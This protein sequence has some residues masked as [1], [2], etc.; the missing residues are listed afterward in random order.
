MN[1]NDDITEDAFSA[2]FDEAASHSSDPSANAG[3]DDGNSDPADQR[4]DTSPGDQPGNQAPAA[5]EGPASQ[6]DIWSNAPEHLRKA[7][8]E[9]RRDSEHRLN[10][11][12]GRLSAADRQ[13]NA[14]R[15]S[16]PGQPAQQEQP[17]DTP[18]ADDQQGDDGFKAFEEEYPEVA[19]PVKGIVSKLTAEIDRLKGTVETVEG[20]RTTA[21]LAANTEALTQ[22]H[23]DWFEIAKDDRFM[24]WLD[25]QPL[26]IKQA[27]QRNWDNVVDPADASLVFDRWKQTMGGQP[28]AKDTT[29]ADAAE[30]RARQLAAGRDARTKAPSTT[31]E[32]PDDFDTAF[33]T[34]A[35]KAD[36]ERAKHRHPI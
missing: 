2:A 3:G 31:S 5:P 27:A 17:S 34:A 29:A 28:P 9:L 13:L 6:D 22:A 15:N 30:K 33:D 11:V 1:P 20:E 21:I 12:K 7:Y 4:A 16:Q 32:E 18:T 25:S 23:P 36:G 10:S 8:E 14:L 19:G 26:A 35:R 24:G